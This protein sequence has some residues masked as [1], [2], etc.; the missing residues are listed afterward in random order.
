MQNVNVKV[1]NCPNLKM[2]NV[3]A[4]AVRIVKAEMQNVYEL[5]L[6]TRFCEMYYVYEPILGFA[7]R[8]E[9]YLNVGE[10]KT[11]FSTRSQKIQTCLYGQKYFL[12]IIHGVAARQ[13]GKNAIPRICTPGLF[14]VFG[15]G[16]G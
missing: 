5:S 10:V 15:G 7:P 6:T 16:I 4:R 12:V 9:K 3:Y 13:S 2:Q 8:G 11:T 1:K 14:A